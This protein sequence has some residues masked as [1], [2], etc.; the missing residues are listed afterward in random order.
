V[1]CKL[2]E[3]VT[4]VSDS[5]TSQMQCDKTDPSVNYSDF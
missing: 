1:S 5:V 2:F 3:T 4:T